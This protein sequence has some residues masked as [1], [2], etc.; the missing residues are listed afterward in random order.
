MP[1]S[2]ACPP[3]CRQPRILRGYGLRQYR[4][5]RM[6]PSRPG[7]PLLLRLGFMAAPRSSAKLLPTC[8]A[9]PDDARAHAHRPRVRGFH[10][11]RSHFSKARSSAPR[12]WRPPCLLRR[13]SR[14]GYGLRSGPVHR[15]YFEVQVAGFAPF[16]SDDE[17]RHLFASDAHVLDPAAFAEQYDRLV[18]VK[19]GP[20]SRLL[21]KAVGGREFDAG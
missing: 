13:S 14:S 16:F 2:P 6:A 18:L 19:G 21:T 8:H 5:H 11:Q 12:P 4:Q 1:T 7:W 17:I 3:Y 9:G 20:E 10:L 15:G